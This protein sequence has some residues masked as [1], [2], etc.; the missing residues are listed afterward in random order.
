MHVHVTIIGLNRVGTS[1]GLALKRYQSQPAAQHSFTIIGSD[2]ENEPMKTAHKMGAIDNFQRDKLKAV[3][4]AELIFTNLPYGETE[5][6]FARIGPA[7]KPGAVVL[8]LS[9]LKQPALGWADEFF[10]RNAQGSALAYLVGITPILNANALYSGGID[11]QDARADLFDDAEILIAPDPQCPPEAVQ[12][13]EDVTRLLGAR[14]RF[15]D[16]AEHD[17]LIAATEE[18]PALLGATLFYTLEQSDGWTE[19]RRM[20]NPTLALAFQSLRTRTQ[21]DALAL[22]THNRANV[23]HHLDTLIARLGEVRHALAAGGDDAELEA[24]LGLVYRA[25]QKW[26][27]KRT[28]GNW[29]EGRSVE[30]LPGPL[31]AMGG[32]LFGRRLRKSDNEDA[33]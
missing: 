15:M 7:L 20:V 30:P 3:D 32:M 25:W 11:A 1:V 33:D 22:L 9:L 27:A 17:G 14:P 19:L 10:V 29:D 31:G 26:D 24:F 2:N 5:G 6:L 21:A 13:A 28:S 18:L 23:L 4:G 8:D 12:L 16:P